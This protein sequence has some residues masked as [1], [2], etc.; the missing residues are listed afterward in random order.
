MVGDTPYD[1]EAATE[2]GAAAA[3][4]LA[5]GFSSEA[6]VA[7]GCFAVADS[8]RALLPSL[9]HGKAVA[10]PSDHTTSLARRHV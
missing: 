9:E 6:L 10:T 4:V 5:G 7:A 2:A 8:L 1:A 3:G